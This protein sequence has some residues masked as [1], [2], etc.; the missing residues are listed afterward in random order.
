MSGYEFRHYHQNKVFLLEFCPKKTWNS[1]GWLLCAIAVVMTFLV[2]WF[3]RSGI[4]WLVFLITL[5][6]FVMGLVLLTLQ[7]MTFQLNLET[8]TAHSS[9]RF[10]GLRFNKHQ[11]K[12]NTLEQ[13]EIE[14]HDD[15]EDG[16]VDSLVLLQTDGSRQ[17]L[18]RMIGQ[19]SSQEIACIEAANTFL[20]RRV[21]I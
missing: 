19:L 21:G 12:L 17:P 2:F 15:A 6:A 9:I 5:P 11:T 18:L 16:K 4:P 7:P 13:I 8:N 10:L 14:S 3:D 1:S 20:G